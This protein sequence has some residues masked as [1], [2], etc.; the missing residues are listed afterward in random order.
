[1]FG[2]AVG[3]KDARIAYIAPNYQQARDIAWNEL[4]RIT[5][6]VQVSVN[7]S[8]LEVRIQNQ[9][10]GESFIVLRGWESIDTLRG[11]YF[12]FIVLDEVSSYR[13]FWE[14]WQEVIRPTLTDRKGEALFI[15]TPKGFNHFYDLY[16]FERKDPDYKSFHFTTY[17]NPHVPREEVDKAKLELTEDRFA[18]EYMADFRKTE[19]LVYKEFQRAKHLRDFPETAYATKRFAG[20]DFGTNNPAAVLEIKKDYD[21]RYL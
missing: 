1:M 8:R 19:G 17:D 10:G 7:E 18:Q 21:G 3:R 14:H 12:D 4:K 15:S 13:N 2:F 16:N 6:P 11:Q 5:H 9:H 20:V